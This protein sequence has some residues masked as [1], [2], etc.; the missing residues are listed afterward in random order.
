[1]KKIVFILLII[2][3]MIIFFACNK[4]DEEI[5]QTKYV[6]D[7]ELYENDAVLM[8]KVFFTNPYEETLETLVFNLYPNA[9]AKDAKNKAYKEKL[10]RYGG[11]ELTEV[12][13]NGEAAEFTLS[14]TKHQVTVT[15]PALGKGDGAEIFFRCIVTIPDARLRL[16]RYNGV[17]NMG[18]FYPVLAVYENGS[19]RDDEFSIVGDPFYTSVADYDVTIRTHKD[20]FIA[21]GGDAYTTVEGDR[22]VLKTT[23]SNSR[24]FAFCASRNFKVLEQNAGKVKV[25]YF[26]LNDKKAEESLLT[27][28]QAI[29]R[30][31]KAIMDY[32]YPTFNV[33]ET[34]FDYGG[35]EYPSLVYVS[36]TALDKNQ[37][38]VHETAHQWWYGIVGVDGFN[39]AYIDEGLATFFE[40]YFYNLDG[41]RLRFNEHA[42]KLKTDYASYYA[43]NRKNDNF[44]AVLK[45]NL[46]SFGETE[47][48]SICYMRSAIMFRQAYD[49]L[50][51]EGF[52]K[53][54][55]IL[56][57]ENAFGEINTEKLLD[58]FNRGYGRN[59]E[60]FF[61]SYIEGRTQDVFYG[62][63]NKIDI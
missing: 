18:N 24:D 42:K 4:K 54:L 35:M 63:S 53:S 48:D 57:S 23:L 28:C 22:K 29:E 44:S 38:I 5:A 9:Y 25:R 47:Y 16:G 11:I 43:M 10:L 61:L 36:T 17:Y 8:Q 62:Y 41:D 33:V 1:M 19:F 37:I 15:V 50:G 46:S 27:A 32:P 13:V 40:G 20:L 58:A 52:E 26:Y 12:S 2:A 3:V 34:Y 7:I 51:S 59:V 31:G 60:G 39:E 21:A 49:I 30:F 45:K 14:E 55:K 56:C 6:I